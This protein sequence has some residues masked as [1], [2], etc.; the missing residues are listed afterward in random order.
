MTIPAKY[1]ATCS[2]CHGRI[3]RGQQIKWVR[4]QPIRHATCGGTET[5]LG[6]T[7]KVPCPGC[8]RRGATPPQKVRAGFQCNVCA[9][10][11]EG[12]Y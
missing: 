8:I 12:V 4:G 5:Q 9:D 1:S 7:G 11:E 2:V 3:S 10:I 6:R